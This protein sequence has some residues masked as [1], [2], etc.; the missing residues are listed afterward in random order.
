[1]G[2]PIWGWVI[3]IAVVVYL[4]RKLIIFWRKYAK[5]ENEQIRKN[6]EILKK[7][8][9][10]VVK[11]KI[12]ERKLFVRYINVHTCKLYVEDERGEFVSSEYDPDR[13]E[14]AEEKVSSEKK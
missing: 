8:L 14:I 11:D 6:S 9:K 13:V 5:E 1:M 3:I 10:K 2:I 12:S 4:G 7:Y